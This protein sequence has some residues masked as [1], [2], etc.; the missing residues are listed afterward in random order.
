MQSL[1]ALLAWKELCSE[2]PER[3]FFSRTR[4]GASFCAWQGKEPPKATSVLALKDFLK[5]WIELDKARKSINSLLAKLD[6]K[7]VSSSLC[8]RHVVTV[9]AA[10]VSVCHHRWT[11]TPVPLHVKTVK[12]CSAISAMEHW[13]WHMLTEPSTAVHSI[14]QRHYPKYPKQYSVE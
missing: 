8:L 6:I 10:R 13:C 9:W 11:P 14:T 3:V 12:I 7:L 2:S 4:R 1:L 5:S